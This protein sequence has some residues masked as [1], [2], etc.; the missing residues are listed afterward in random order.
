MLEAQTELYNFMKVKPTAVIALEIGGGNGLQGMILGAS[1][2]MNIPTVDGDWMGR[3]YPVA[4]QTTPVVFEE[5]P[6]FLPSTICDG[7]GQVMFMT[8]AKSELMVERAFRAALSQMGS[9]VGCAKG[10]ISGKNTKS[11]VVEHTISLS[12]R[13]GR[14]VALSRSLN[15]IDTVAES[16]ISEVGGSESAKI[17]FKGKIVGVERTLRMGHVYGEV[18]IEGMSLRGEGESEFKGRLKIPFKNENIVAIR[19]EDGGS[20]TVRTFPSLHIS[21]ADSDFI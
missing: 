15:Q 21:Q 20:E 13:I 4:W 9:H 12:W 18:I 6:V 19:D 8:K 11:W 14:A 17:L 16:I 10:P 5:K 7:N 3:A 2:M 1:N